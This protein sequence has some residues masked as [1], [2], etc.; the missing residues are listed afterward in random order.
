MEQ[1]LNPDSKMI[2][3]TVKEIAGKTLTDKNYLYLFEKGTQNLINAYIEA[4]PKLEKI[5]LATVDYFKLS[6]KW[7]EELNNPSEMSKGITVTEIDEISADYYRKYESISNKLRLLEKF[8]LKTTPLNEEERK[9]VN[10]IYK[11]INDI[12]STEISPEV[13][14][15]KIKEIKTYEESKL[16]RWERKDQYYSFIK[17]FVINEDVELKDKLETFDKLPKETKERFFQHGVE[18]T[19]YSIQN[20]KQILLSDKA[21]EQVKNNHAIFINELSNQKVQKDLVTFLKET[22]IKNKT[23]IVD[24]KIVVEGDLDFSRHGDFSPV[25]KY[26]P[27]NLTVNGNLNFENGVIE[28]LPKNLTVNGH[29]NLF[30]SEIE[31]LSEDLKVKGNLD[32]DASKIKELPKN[33]NVGGNLSLK[34][35]KIT[36]LPEN[37]TVNKNLIL[38]YTNIEKLPKDLKVRGE[39]D[40]R[41]TPLQINNKEMEQKFDKEKYL[42]NQMKYLGFGESK[43]LHEA[44]KKGI[45]G[46]ENEFQ[47][48]TTSHSDKTLPGNSINFNLNFRKTENGSVFLNSYDAN[49]TNEK[50]EVLSHRFK[51]K[52]EDNITAKESINLLEGRA[53]KTAFI[54]SKTNEKEPT[55]IKLKLNEEKNDY[56]NYKLDFYNAQNIDLPK[57]IEKS[58]LIFDKE[59]YK[60]FTLKSLEKGNLA[61][62][63][64]KHEGNDIEGK[65]SLNP[66]YKT[67][68]L[69]DSEMNR[70]NTNK[71]IK[72]VD[73]EENEKSRI[74]QHNTKRS[75]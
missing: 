56:G 43:E 21:I 51:V 17:D 4:N 13:T 27:E 38:R 41:D 66:Q 49:L 34:N 42:Q 47:I 40:L 53:V 62:V 16:E 10:E 65:A 70:L 24:N 29:L 19:V 52:K 54:N 5:P 37:L 30:G 59:E 1:N 9:E 8:E 74:R 58:N 15:T 64:F 12:K 36:E 33:L 25:I 72:G 35:T 71:P 6:K 31:S 14:D 23:E 20:E 75:L 26:L 32:L 69:Y 61:T 45:E 3:G 44:L 57:I 22:G 18:D 48:K 67:L 73:I 2:G 50:G 11:Q 46:N 60:D 68:N 55:F 7:S 39:L 63:K 28:K